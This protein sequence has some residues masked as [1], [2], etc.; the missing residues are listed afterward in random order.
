MPYVHLLA[1]YLKPRDSMRKIPV[2]AMRDLGAA[3]E[4]S[5]AL[6]KHGYVLGSLELTIRRRSVTS[7]RCS[8]WIRP[9]SAPGTW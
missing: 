4:V 7:R 1:S 8:R 6:Q 9:T 2:A 5:A 3:F